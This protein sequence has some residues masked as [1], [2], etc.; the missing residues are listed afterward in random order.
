MSQ[1]RGKSIDDCVVEREAELSWLKH[2]TDPAAIKRS[3]QRITA[4]G[5]RIQRLNGGN[6][7]T[8]HT[9]LIAEA[10]KYAAAIYLAT[11]GAVADD[12]SRII[13]GLTDSLIQSERDLVG[14]H[15]Q[16]VIIKAVREAY[17]N[18]GS[19]PEYHYH[20]KAWL[21]RSWPMLAKA[22]DA[23][24]DASTNVTQKEKT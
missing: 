2:L 10:K 22:L 9:N 4:L 20:Q 3:K 23:L 17:L 11:D 13:R 16:A 12:V 18:P 19:H 15:E 1:N 8:D 5:N 7:M 21:I 6:T 14:M 24:T